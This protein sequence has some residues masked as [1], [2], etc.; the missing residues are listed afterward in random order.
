M[1]YQFAAL[2]RDHIKHSQC[3]LQVSS[4]LL[5]GRTGKANKAFWRK[6]SDMLHKVPNKAKGLVSHQ[7][8]KAHDTI[9]NPGACP[10][11]IVPISLA[12]SS[13]C[14]R[15]TMYRSATTESAVPVGRA[16]VPAIPQSPRPSPISDA[17]EMQKGYEK[18]TRVG[19]RTGV[20][21]CGGVELTAGTSA[22]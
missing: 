13:D 16:D 8:R 11:L 22:E 7:H 14:P 12:R 3:L 9:I 4:S 2:Q 20:A 6:L 18:T 10:N 15:Q 1:R 17:P 5:N 21:D 19:C